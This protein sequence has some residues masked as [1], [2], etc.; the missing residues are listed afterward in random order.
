MLFKAVISYV[1]DTFVQ[2][3]EPWCIVS[4]T[5]SPHIVYTDVER[6]SKQFLN[7]TSSGYLTA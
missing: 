3:N 2:Q 1:L 5:L 6:V 7:D 4:N